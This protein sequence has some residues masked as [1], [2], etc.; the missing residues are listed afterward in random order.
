M[1]HTYNATPTLFM[2]MKLQYAGYKY[3]SL[4]ANNDITLYNL[5]HTVYKHIVLPSI[6]PAYN[7][8]VGYITETLF[9]TDST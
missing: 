9:D 1:E 4:L 8:G 7:F 3:C 2:P 5:D 6:S